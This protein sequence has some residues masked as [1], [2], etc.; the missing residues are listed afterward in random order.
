MNVNGGL[1]TKEEEEKVGL[2]RRM[3]EIF[4]KRE[5]ITSTVK[6]KRNC[7]LF[8]TDRKQKRTMVKP[9]M[10]INRLNHQIKTVRTSSYHYSLAW[11]TYM[12][13]KP[14]NLPWSTRLT[15]PITQLAHTPLLKER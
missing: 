2:P 10:H 8:L 3:R 1:V 14:R 12:E 6:K 11:E 15:P 13:G 4:N 9:K 5:K 7:H